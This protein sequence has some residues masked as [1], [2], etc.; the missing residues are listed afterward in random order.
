M[1]IAL[2]SLPVLTVIV[3]PLLGRFAC[4]A[5]IN[6]RLASLLSVNFLERFLGKDLA[7]E[8]KTNVIV[9]SI[10]YGDTNLL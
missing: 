4:F 5:V 6:S 10:I 9:A 7:L 8:D 1:L 3:S 2:P